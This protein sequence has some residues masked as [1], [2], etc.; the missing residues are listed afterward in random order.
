MSGEGL[1]GQ[2]RPIGL[3]GQ[4]FVDLWHGVVASLELITDETRG[5]QGSK[6]RDARDGDG[7]PERRAVGTLVSNGQVCV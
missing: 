3:I 5:K 1:W 4:G 7:R 2:I 6:V